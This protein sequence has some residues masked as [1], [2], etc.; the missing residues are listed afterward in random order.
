MTEKIMLVHGTTG[1]YVGNIAG[2]PRLK[3]PPIL[4]NDGPQG[5]RGIPGTST[6]FPSGLTGAN[7]GSPERTLPSH[8]NLS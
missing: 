3:I 5:F 1:P 4:M 8:H 6:A 2:I 7:R